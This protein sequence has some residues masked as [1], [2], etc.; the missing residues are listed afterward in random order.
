MRPLRRDN[1]CLRKEV[2][3][4]REYRHKA[5]PDM[6]KDIRDTKLNSLV[7]KTQHVQGLCAVLRVWDVILNAVGRCL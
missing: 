1:N 3:Q 7:S 5:G 4:R 2:V 6:G